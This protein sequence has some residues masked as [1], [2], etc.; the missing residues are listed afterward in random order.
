MVFNQSVRTDNDIDA[1]VKQVQDQY[2]SSQVNIIGHSAG[3]W[4]ARIYLGEI[5][6]LSMAM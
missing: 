3:G 5:P 2:A 6:Y 4:I 1:T